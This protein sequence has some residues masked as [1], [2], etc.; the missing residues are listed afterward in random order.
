[1]KLIKLST[2]KQQ[3]DQCRVQNELQAHVSNNYIAVYKL[4]TAGY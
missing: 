4:N 1:M 3:K 2:A